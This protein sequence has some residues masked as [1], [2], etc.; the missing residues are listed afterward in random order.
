MEDRTRRIAK[1]TVYLYI[2]SLVTMLVGLYTSRVQLEALGIDNYGINTLILGIAGF[3]S[4]ISLG[5]S[6]GT[7][8][9]ITFA[10]GEGDLKRMR[11]VFSTLIKVQFLIA[12]IAVFFLEVAGGWFLN[13]VAE[14]PEGRLYAA[15]WVL[16]CTIFSVFVTMAITPFRATIVARERM[17]VYAYMSII[18][19]VAKLS[20][21]FA[22]L[23]YGGDRLILFSSLWLVATVCI[24]LFYVLFCR[25]HFDEIR[26]M[27]EIDKTLL[28]DIFKFS[29]W[30]IVD[31]VVWIFS[32]QG[33][34]MLVNVFFGVVYNAALG[35]AISVNNKASELIA[36]FTTAFAPQI[37]KSY[38]AK[39]YDYCYNLVN[40]TCKVSWY[41]MY[42]FIVPVC[43]EADTLLSIWLVEVPKDSALFLRFV[44][45]QSLTVTASQN[46][47]RLIQAHGVLKSYTI[48][49]S[50]I[51]GL[52]FPLSWLLFA[53]GAPVCTTFVTFILLYIA[54]L[55]LRLV[56]LRRL[57]S[58]KI[59][60]YFSQVLKPCVSVSVLSFVL[61]LVITRFWEPSLLRFLILTPI[62]VI[63]TFAVIYA[64]GLTDSER[65]M[66]NSKIRNIFLSRVRPIFVKS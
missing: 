52:C 14:I 20:I 10:L 61:P 60:S 1:N 48:K 31:N 55:G 3:A 35:F 47:F 51:A 6:A 24:E 49:F 46:L 4:I 56:T 22:I 63:N 16:Q 29:G 50:I 45:F 18:D 7:S 41:L 37:T 53:L 32:N 11:L 15:N 28:K 43:I 62:C 27:R 8:R 12:V 26:Y 54:V 2:R 40:R 19:A 34:N 65:M 23:Y 39:D 30:S 58:Y 42:I 38:A 44:M 5:M 25:Y 13:F 57:T 66:L 59:S 21:C 33:I 9:F 64:I 17:S 36:S